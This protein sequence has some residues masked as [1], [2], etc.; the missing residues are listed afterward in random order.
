MEIIALLI[1]VA[2]YKS[3]DIQDLPFCLNDISAIEETFNRVIKIPKKNIHVLS[4]NTSRIEI[5]KKLNQINLLSSSADLLLL[6]FTGHGASISGNGYLIPSD[7]EL[8][9][10]NDTAIPI[11]RFQE[12]L[13]GSSAKNKILIIDSCFSGINLGK[14]TTVESFIEDL[15][16]LTSMG[17]TI[18]SSSKGNEVSHFIEEKEMSVF[19]YY[20]NEALLEQ[21][22][23]ITEK[24]E[25]TVDE[26]VNTVTKKVAEWSLISNIVQT[27]TIK[28]ERIGKFGIQIFPIDSEPVEAENAPLLQPDDIRLEHQFYISS[29][30]NTYSAINPFLTGT[31]IPS[32]VPETKWV[33]YTDSERRRYKTKEITEKLEKLNGK[34]LD[35]IVPSQI[36]LQGTSTIKYPFAVLNIIDKEEFKILFRLTIDSKSINEKTKEI[37]NSIDNQDPIEWQTLVFTYK[38]KIDF[39]KIMEISKANKYKISSFDIMHN[40]LSVDIL[41]G[42]KSNLQM[43]FTNNEDNC[44]ITIKE[45][46]KLRKD[47]FE[48]VPL[49]KMIEIFNTAVK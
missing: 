19:S 11:K 2:T 18:I 23:K 46:E 38:R 9:M 20:L 27:P 44:T 13:I 30:Y 41:T 37:L 24:T 22:S 29:G 25:L 42:D 33:S 6:Y 28:S 34:L 45:K 26:I 35:F 12:L 21:A 36:I 5:L 17:W 1:G 7:T 39:D 8:T 32:V 15:V 43:T 31:Y 10:I 4:K 16:Q 3:N 49:D 48:V 47:F 40:K 14:Q